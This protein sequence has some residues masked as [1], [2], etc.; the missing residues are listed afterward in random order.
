EHHRPADVDRPRTGRDV[1]SPG[2]RALPDLRPDGRSQLRPRRLLHLGRLRRLVDRRPRRGRSRPDRRVP[3]RAGGRHAR[4]RGVGGGR[5]DRSPAPALPPPD[6]PG[7]RHPRDRP[8]PQPADVG[9]L[10]AGRPPLSAARLVGGHEHRVRGAGAEQPVSPD[11]RRPRGPRRA[12]PL[13]AADTLR[14][15]RS[16]WRRESGDGPGAGDRRRPRLHPRLRPR[17]GTGRTGRRLR[18]RLLRVDQ[19]ELRL[20]QPHLRLHRRRHRRPRLG[21]RQRPGGGRDRPCPA[22]RQLLH[23]LGWRLRRRLAARRR[24]PRPPAR[25]PRDAAV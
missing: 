7:A 6:L 17:R 18:R 16:R 8:R 21:H 11:R 19:P 13:P 24:P 22:V 25:P 2:G 10:A 23:E 3:P 14:A 9:H 1:F 5:R 15:D 4:G 20:G 12:A